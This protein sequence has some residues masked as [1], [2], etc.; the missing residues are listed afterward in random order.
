MNTKQFAR[1]REQF[2]DDELRK[3]AGKWVAFSGDGKR[4]V[5]SADDL[6]ELDRAVVA[7]GEDPQ[8]V[9][10]ERVVS[11]DTASLIGGVELS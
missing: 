5:A 7:A 9:G 2:P 10:L 1:N 8:E 11:E 6:E 3:Y 4:I